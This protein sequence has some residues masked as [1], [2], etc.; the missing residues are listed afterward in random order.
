[1]NEGEDKGQGENG[2]EKDRTAGEPSCPWSP[3]PHLITPLHASLVP[4]ISIAPTFHPLKFDRHMARWWTDKM[5]EQGEEGK[6]G[7]DE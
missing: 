2:N 5:S 1:V 6:D 7:V 4:L 3:V